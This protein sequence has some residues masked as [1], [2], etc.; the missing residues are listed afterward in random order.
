MTDIRGFGPRCTLGE[1]PLWHPERDRFYWFDIV[2]GTLYGADQHGNHQRSWSFGEPASAAGWVDRDTLLVATASGLQRFDIDAGTWTPVIGIEEDNPV[3]RSNDGRI[4][5]DGSFWI[6]TMG[7]ELERDA[8]A[9]YR[10]KAGELSTLKTPMSVPNATC[11]SPDGRTAYFADTARM[12][13]WRWALDAAGDPV[14][15]YE[16][17]IDM[18]AERLRPD[19]A[20]CDA[21]G[22]LWNA[23]FGAGRVARYAPDGRFDRAIDLPASQTTCPAFGGDGLATLYVT[24]AAQGLEPGAEPLAGHTFM[25]EVGVCGIAE[26][27]VRL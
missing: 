3:T 12:T 11:F 21:E 13:I 14:G 24:S 4:A 5:P 26:H 25:L 22:Y 7:R 23:Q 6:G 16:V 19:G 17:H 8:G 10:Y 18:K 15:D 20:V 1:G 27:Q 2:A 9:Q